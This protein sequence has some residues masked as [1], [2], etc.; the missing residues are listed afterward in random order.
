MTTT[1]GAPG[2]TLTAI[3]ALMPPDV[4]VITDMPWSLPVITPAA[5]IAAMVVSELFQV[6]SVA[7]DVPPDAVVTFAVACTDVPDA[8]LVVETDITSLDD[9]SG[10][11][12]PDPDP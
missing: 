11:V 9:A 2:W 3:C 4:A 7:G 12:D 10:A 1:A 8:M 6:T 5:L